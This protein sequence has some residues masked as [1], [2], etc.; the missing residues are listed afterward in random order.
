VLL[1][2][3]AEHSYRW[4]AADELRGVEQLTTAM[5]SLAENAI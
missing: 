1:D 2:A 3:G 5:N 4:S